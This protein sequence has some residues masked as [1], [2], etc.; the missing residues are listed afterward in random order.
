MYWKNNLITPIN[1]YKLN[2]KVILY[3]L[4]LIIIKKLTILIESII[5]I[6]FISA[7]RSGRTTSLIESVKTD[8]RVVFVNSSEAARVKYLCKQRNIN[9]ETIVIDPKNPS[10]LF[11]KGSV[12]NDGRL[13]FDHAWVEEY[14]LNNIQD[15]QKQI[16]NYQREISG[17]GIAHIETKLKAEEAYKWNQ[18][19]IW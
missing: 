2:L 15:A 17:Y 16:D 14:Y 9:I 12:L 13:I 1:P 4:S 19:F 18:R 5:K 7:R 3:K 11:N 8:D 6:Y 10:S